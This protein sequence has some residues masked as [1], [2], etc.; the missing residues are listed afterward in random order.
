M[1]AQVIH[2]QEA[3]ALIFLTSVLHQYNCFSSD[4]VAPDLQ[5]ACFMEANCRK[6]GRDLKGKE[7]G[8]EENKVIQIKMKCAAAKSHD[9]V[10][11]E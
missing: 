7:E 2:Y 6:G 8:G 4:R 10:R 5:G 11:K 1:V 9:A 3:Q